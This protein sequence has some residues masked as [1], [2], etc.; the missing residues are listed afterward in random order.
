MLGERVQGSKAEN[1]SSVWPKKKKK[2]LKSPQKG[3]DRTAKFDDSDLSGK[4]NKIATVEK[5]SY[6]TLL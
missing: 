5:L 1:D 4:N 3:L 2:N 6:F